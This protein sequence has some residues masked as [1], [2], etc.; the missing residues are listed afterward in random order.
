M[1]L[2]DSYFPVCGLPTWSVW[3]CFYQVIVLPTS[4]CG[5][6]FVL[7]SRISFWKFPSIWLKVVQPVLKFFVI[8]SLNLCFINMCVCKN[9]MCRGQDLTRMDSLPLYTLGWVWGLGLGED[10][11]TVQGTCRVCAQPEVIPWPSMYDLKQIFSNLYICIFSYLSTYLKINKRH[12]NMLREKQ[13]K[14]KKIFP[15]FWTEA[16]DFHFKINLANYLENPA[17]SNTLIMWILLCWSN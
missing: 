3:G 14:M 10:R 8:V 17:C 9:S 11:L 6:L 16:S 5:L 4:W 13:W 12:H 1:S 15:D 2:C 7:W